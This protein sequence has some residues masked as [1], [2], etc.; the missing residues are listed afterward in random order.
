MAFMDLP[1]LAL[2][3]K[4]RR[5]ELGLL[6]QDVVDAA[7]SHLSLP[8]LS[9]IENARNPRPHSRTLL[10]LDRGLRWKPG[11][12]KEVLAGGEP[13][14]LID[15]VRA[16]RT[17]VIAARVAARGGGKQ[18]GRALTEA[19]AAY[20]AAQRRVND[21]GGEPDLDANPIGVS[22]IISAEQ[23]SDL[24]NRLIQLDALPEQ[25]A[26]LAQAVAELAEEIRLARGE[27]VR[28]R[29]GGSASSL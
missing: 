26:G 11:S 5:E 10:A 12:A 24:Q 28:P 4:A 7:G 13:V 8:V 29:A 6:Q 14:T 17:A 20:T 27:A 3:A 16:A 2:L 21:V 1:R 15:D 23:W 9:M 25:M 22:F 19:E 18:S